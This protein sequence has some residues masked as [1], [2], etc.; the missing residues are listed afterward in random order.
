LQLGSAG[1]TGNFVVSVAGKVSNALPFTV[2]AGHIYFLDIASADPTADGSF[3]HPWKTLGAAKSAL[4]AGDTLYIEGGRFDVRDPDSVPSGSDAFIYLSRDVFPATTAATPI[5]IVGYPGKRPAIGPATWPSAQDNCQG[6]NYSVLVDNPS[7][8]LVQ[9]LVVANMTLENRLYSLVA[10]GDNLRFVDL[11]FN[12]KCINVE[13]GV[14]HAIGVQLYGSHFADSQ[15]VASL[16][17][18]TANGTGTVRDVDVAWNEIADTCDSFSNLNVYA[19]ASADARDVTFHDNLSRHGFRLATISI[20][21]DNVTFY[22]N[23][24]LQNG[25][26]LLDTNFAGH[27][28]LE[29]NSFFTTDPLFN[30]G[31]GVTGSV[32]LNNNIFVTG[33]VIPT[34]KESQFSGASNLWHNQA[35]PAFDATG[36]AALAGYVDQTQGDLHLA[37]TSAVRGIGAQTTHCM[38]FDGTRRTATP[39]LGAY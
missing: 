8:L 30:F 21:V 31:T 26:L 7:P 12:T 20:G 5:A 24:I 29:N 13:V 23:V 4:A 19:S 18:F 36:S 16:V 6:A 25:Y 1:T 33:K 37:P 11:R 10:T 9:N 17:S 22:N 35:I 34:G 27:L 28:T 15:G 2:R 32:T 3:A 39:D 14:P 38:G